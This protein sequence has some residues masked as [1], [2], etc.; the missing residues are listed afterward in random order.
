MGGTFKRSLWV[1]LASEHPSFCGNAHGYCLFNL[2]IGFDGR[3][4]GGLPLSR[5][6]CS[7]I[8]GRM[9]DQGDDKTL[10]ASKSVADQNREDRGNM[11]DERQA[12]EDLPP[13]PEHRLARLWAFVP[14][15]VL[16]LV[17]LMPAMYVD[18]F[19]MLPNFSLFG[20]SL[21]DAATPLMLSLPLFIAGAIKRWNWR[22]ILLMM[23]L[24]LLA[25]LVLWGTGHVAPK[26]YSWTWVV[27]YNAV[28]IA[29]L[30]VGE[31][32]CRKRRLRRVAFWIAAGAIAVSAV[33]RLGF[34]WLWLID[35]NISLPHP[36]GDDVW[37]FCWWSSLAYL[38][39]WPILVVLAWLVLPCCLRI[40][41][42]RARWARRAFCG[43]LAVMVAASWGF[44]NVLSFP[45]AEKSVL[46]GE[47]FDRDESVIWLFWRNE[48]SDSDLFWR[49][50]EN[51]PWT[52]S[53][54]DVRPP[55]YGRIDR[56]WRLVA[57]NAL[58]GRDSAGTAERLAAMLRRQPNLYLA[59]DAADVLAK[60]KTYDAVPHLMRFSL[61]D[62]SFVCK[63]AMVEMGL[64]RAAIAIVRQAIVFEVRAF[65]RQLQTLDKETCD[66]L[67]GMLG[68]D[69]GNSVRAWLDLY[70]ETIAER[71]TPLP[72]DIK[73]ETD[74]TIRAVTQ[75]ISIA[76]DFFTFNCRRVY[77]EGPRGE[78]AEEALNEMQS[79]VSEPDWTVPTVA[80]LEREVEDY[81]KRV[82]AAM[83]EAGSAG[84][85]AAKAP[86]QE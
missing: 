1:L 9:H 42:D 31:A 45:L 3:A 6:A 28:P 74:R 38:T 57:V 50:L 66:L 4:S 80:E 54:W 16:G 12:A 73:V 13:S 34:R 48:E 14:T 11:A 30:A 67:K 5:A 40:W 36:Y 68:K 32:W 20:G 78:A 86:I 10:K 49:A 82:N 29:I 63:D 25:R 70:D 52:H 59:E 24:A 58:A 75:Y 17:L 19:N 46:A 22:H 18:H 71:P 23:G 51:E 64:P 81:R 56:A 44:I 21:E 27:L 61:S 84:K 15:W 85:G 33:S 72:E 83:A 35:W 79:A 77:E 8:I 41:T 7:S 69:V 37:D 53:G 65:G 55:E 47:P 2:G 60:N 76:N 26:R 43:M 39:R 62:E